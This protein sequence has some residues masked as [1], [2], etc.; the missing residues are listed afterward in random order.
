MK[1]PDTDDPDPANAFA[2][3]EGVRVIDPQSPHAGDEGT[4]KTIARG[5]GPGQRWTWYFVA[6]PGLPA[7]APAPFRYF[8]LEAVT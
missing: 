6:L 7:E 2:L 5:A 1:P 8:Q 4:V 3:G